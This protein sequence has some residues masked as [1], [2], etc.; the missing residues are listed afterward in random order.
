MRIMVKK[1][2]DHL[3]YLVTSPGLALHDDIIYEEE[4]LKLVINGSMSNYMNV[5][6]TNVVLR[7]STLK[8]TYQKILKHSRIPRQ[9]VRHFSKI[10]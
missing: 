8:V 9:K 6:A 10:F 1:S 5:D 2:E 7:G 4:S 3:R